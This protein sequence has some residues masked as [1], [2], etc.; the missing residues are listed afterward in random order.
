MDRTASGGGTGPT[1]LRLLLSALA[2]FNRDKGFFLAA[3][4]SFNILLSLIPMIMLL[5]SVFGSYLYSDA[6]IVEHIAQYFESV[7]PTL[8]PQISRTLVQL[9]QNRQ[10]VGLVGFAGLAWTATIVFTSLRISLNVVFDVPKGRSLVRGLAVDLLMVVLSGALLLASMLLTSWIRVVERFHLPLLPD[11]GLLLRLG[12]KY[13]FPFLLTL[14]MCYFVYEIVPNTSV[15]APSAL[16]G[17]AIF[18][19]LW[20]TAKQGF[21]WYVM[22]AG[23]YSLLYGSLGTVAVLFLWINYSTIIF[24][25]GGEVAYF[26]DQKRLP[27]AQG[28]PAPDAGGD[29]AP[30]LRA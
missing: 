7:V 17:A 2:K 24:L 28:R 1:G 30:F 13:L 10:L 6:E 23:S 18:S 5:L 12:I 4:I 11:P 29:R 14:I 15:S 27:P 20:E 26:L 3:A 21:S 25:L 22:H 19:V 8:D 16:K 9:M